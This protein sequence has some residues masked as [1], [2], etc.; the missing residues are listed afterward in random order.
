M[1]REG[2]G[3]F[4]LIEALVALVV[5]GLV[6]VTM[7]A[8]SSQALRV[9]GA[10]LDHRRAAALADAKMSEIAALPPAGLRTYAEGLAGRF[11]EGNERFAWSA[12]VTE[13]P[14]SPHL[15]RAVLRVAWDGGSMEVAT[16]LHHEPRIRSGRTPWGAP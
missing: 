8:A 13:V 10:T 14:E 11:G 15:F 7:A 2:E 4:T 9:E 5:L 1:S 6:V 16:V 12:R 3:G